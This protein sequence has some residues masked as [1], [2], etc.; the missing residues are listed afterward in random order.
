MQGSK[1]LSIACGLLT[2]AGAAHAADACAP[3]PATAV[4]RIS[5]LP[6]EVQ[7]E[8]LS[9]GPVSD[10]GGPFDPGDVFDALHPVPGQRLISGQA[11]P[12]CIVL[13]IEKGGRGYSRALLHFERTGG[14]WALVSL[15]PQHPARPR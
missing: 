13:M 15:A 11:G 4:V 6:D 14:R 12:D 1:P 3:Q 2:L 10:P 9:M 7:A 5:Q 8:L